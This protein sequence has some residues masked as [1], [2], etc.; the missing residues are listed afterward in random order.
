[1]SSGTVLDTGVSASVSSYVQETRMMIAGECTEH[2]VVSA[3]CIAI[4]SHFIQTLPPFWTRKIIAA[5]LYYVAACD[6]DF[7]I[8]LDLKE[9]TSN[10]TLAPLLGSERSRDA[11]TPVADESGRVG[12]RAGQEKRGKL[13]DSKDAQWRKMI[14]DILRDNG[15]RLIAPSELQTIATVGRGGYGSVYSCKW[16]GVT[17]ARKEIQAQDTPTGSS[18]RSS[19]LVVDAKYKLAQQL[20]QEVVRYSAII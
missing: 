19:P 16:K 7:C 17:V 18:S 9:A 10:T 12:N 15:V 1:M 11:A 13:Q 5:V 14:H 3:L 20:V 2:F 8:N 6:S 4:D